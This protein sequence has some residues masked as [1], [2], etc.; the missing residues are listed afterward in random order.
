MILKFRGTTT[1]TKLTKHIKDIAEDIQ[2]RADIISSSIK[3][4]DA[5]VGVIFTVDGKPVYLDVEHE[6]VKEVF[7]MMVQLDEKGN[8][9]KEVD[10][11]ETSFLD[12]YSRSIAK[13][14]VLTYKPIK[15]KFNYSDM[16]IIKIEKIDDELT[17]KSY[18]HKKT[19]DIVHQYYK[20]SILVGEYSTEQ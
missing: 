15:S 14:E 2:K 18:R 6:G 20:D 1:L 12:N 5:E 10:N 7:T 8:I 19:N 9:V 17:I 13:G 3:V 16:A 4:K 11:E